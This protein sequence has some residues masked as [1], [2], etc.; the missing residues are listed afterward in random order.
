M[1]AAC[2]LKGAI[3]LHGELEGRDRSVA[4]QRHDEA[5]QG[6]TRYFWRGTRC[7]EANELWY[8]IGLVVVDVVPES[9]CAVLIRER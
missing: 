5:T 4:Q 7:H 1:Q 2:A 9:L 3:L 8:A 6:G